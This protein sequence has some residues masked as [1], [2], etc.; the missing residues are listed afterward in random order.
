ME[1]IIIYDD[2]FGNDDFH[3]ILDILSKL[4][5]EYGH[6]SNNEKIITPFWI[7]NLM[8]NVFFSEY[9]KKIIES[10]FAKNFELERVYANGQTFG[11]NGS[12]HRDD[13]RNNAYTFCLYAT[14]I[15]E[16]DAKIVDGHIHIKIPNQQ[17]II[18]IEP[19]HNRGILF[20]SN[21]IHKGCAFS[22]YS[23]DMRICIAWKLIEKDIKV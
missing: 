23:A 8:D 14:K 11:Q 1:N 7:I 12:Y 22:R 15:N 6:V 21:Y 13:E 5:W 3:I 2:F 9:L 4:K 19:I 16:N 18:S 10:K 17:Y 20:P